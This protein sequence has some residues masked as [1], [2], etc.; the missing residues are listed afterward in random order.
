MLEKRLVV[1]SV[2]HLNA[3]CFV[4]AF[5]SGE[6]AA[7]ARAGQFLMVSVTDAID[8]L[9]RRPMAFC[10]LLGPVTARTG[11]SILVERTGRGTTLMSRLQPETELEVL[12][13]L[14]TAFRPPSD[15]EDQC[16]LVMG[17]VGSAPFPLLAGDLI[18]A[19]HDVTAFI[20]GRT[21]DHLLCADDL[22]RLGARVVLATDDGSAGHHGLVTEPLQHHLDEA[23]GGVTVY[24][25]GPTPMMRAVDDIARARGLPHQVSLEA[26]MA[27]GI[28][29]CLSCV[30]PVQEADGGWSYQRICREGPVFDADS[31]IWEHPDA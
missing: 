20:G 11:F 2:R 3:R 22:D 7:A 25:C 18:A 30:V 12:A 16:C 13:P 26:P 28:G 1:D 27:C 4:V 15:A 31:L 14:G 23:T 8:P 5:R 19:G 6:V 24:S 21:A 17:G 9:L 29:V 10:E